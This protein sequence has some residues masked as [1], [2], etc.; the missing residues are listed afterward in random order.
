MAQYPLTA[1]QKVPVFPGGA[2]GS[3]LL[4]NSGA[5][6]LY[7]SNDSSVALDGIPINPGASYPYDE[8]M[9]LWAYSPLG[10]TLTVNDGTGNLFDPSAIASQILSQGLAAAIASAIVL[11]PPTVPILNPAKLIATGSFTPSGAP[12]SW[13]M[14]VAIPANTLSIDI[15]V[16]VAG[17]PCTVTVTGNVTSIVYMNNAFLDIN[18]P[19]YLRCPVGPDDTTVQIVG[20]DK[21]GGAAPFKVRVY[22]R[23][24]P[25]VVGAFGTLSGSS[26]DAIGTVPL[27][28]S[29][30]AIAAANVTVAGTVLF[31]V[32]SLGI[33]LDGSHTFLLYYVNMSPLRTI[34]G[35]LT[36]RMILQLG[37]VNQVAITDDN[38]HQIDYN[39]FNCTNLSMGI[40]S[41]G[42]NFGSDYAT[43]LVR[44]LT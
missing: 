34:A 8:Q 11:T 5:N 27:L 10:S 17:C 41:Q 28:P 4:Y 20:Q 14:N 30:V 35:T 31:F 37:G 3:Q 16:D 21:T 7:V 22:A 36:N 33:T 6:V 44:V 15:A 40:L 29:D 9:P 26:N 2:Q 18:G 24:D 1:G 38:F 39:G 19:S 42:G 43:A 12:S 13:L 23:T 25:G 32:P